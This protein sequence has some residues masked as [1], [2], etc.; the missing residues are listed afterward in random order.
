VKLSELTN[1]I[2]T[3]RAIVFQSQC[4]ALEMFVSDRIKSG[5]NCNKDT[6]F[7]LSTAK[8]LTSLKTICNIIPPFAIKWFVTVEL[9]KFEKN[10]TDLV[11]LIKMSTT[12]VYFLRATNYSQ[13]KNIKYEL[14]KCEYILDFYVNWL[15]RDDF[16]Y[17]YTEFVPKENRLNK[18]LFDYV[19]QGYSN[20]VSAV[21]E[22][23]DSLKDGSVIETEA[24]IADICGVG[25]N[26]I[27]SFTMAILKP[28]SQ[29]VNGL[30]IVLRNRIKAGTGLA[31]VYKWDTFHAYLKNS[32]KALIDLKMLYM[33]GIITKHVTNIPASYDEK[34]LVR[35][36]RYLYR[37][38]EIPLTRLIRVLY[39]LDAQRWQT[40]V[41]FIRFIY[42]YT[43][44][45]QRIEGIGKLASIVPS[46]KTNR[47]KE[48]ATKIT[49]E[50]PKQKIE[51]IRKYGIIRAKELSELH[52]NPVK[53]DI[54]KSIEIMRRMMGES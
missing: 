45:S 33:S 52:K 22:L 7:T 2:S 4:S 6:C 40:G 46:V 13:Y 50:S 29:S 53:T 15:R 23:F 10:I 34:K 28:P 24:Q 26:S 48:K 47:I 8:E 21:F 9:E 30:K 32:V 5:L 31:E 27:E 35:Y 12:V 16:L 20:D 17:L 43:Y 38:R 18:K 3:A 11:K 41:D 36:Q 51:L 42:L 54:D 44:E 1:S 49:T 39:F 19:Y 14:R 37:L 25:S